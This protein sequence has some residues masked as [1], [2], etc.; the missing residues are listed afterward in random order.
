M[1]TSQGSSKGI[2][3][4]FSAH[5]IKTSYMIPYVTIQS[6]GKSR[7]ALIFGN[8]I[9]AI[10]KKPRKMGLEPV[11]QGVDPIPHLL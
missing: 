3:Q 11:I 4:R 2:Q 6:P 1:F 8:Q 9:R 7:D 5:K 10:G